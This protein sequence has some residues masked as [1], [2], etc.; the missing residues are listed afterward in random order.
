M[1]LTNVLCRNYQGSLFTEKNKP[2]REGGK[3]IMI[4]IIIITAII[5]N[6]QLFLKDKLPMR[7][8]HPLVSV[9]RKSLQFQD[10]FI[11]SDRSSYSDSV[12]LLVRRQLFQI[13]SISAN[14]FSFSF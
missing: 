7:Q 2:T 4:M 8:Y 13:L 6:W 12:L 3:V 11:S 9:G 14:I 10:D 1:I 5:V